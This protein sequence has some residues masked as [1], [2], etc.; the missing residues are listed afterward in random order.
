MQ[1][2]SRMLIIH[3]I[4]SFSINLMRLSCIDMKEKWNYDPKEEFDL[5]LEW[6]VNHILTKYY[7]VIVIHH[8]RH[9]VYLCMFD[10]IEQA[11]VNYFRS[12][13][14]NYDLLPLKGCEVKTLV[15]GADL[16]VTRRVT[17]RH[18]V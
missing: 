7:N 10:N 9:D 13:V 16:Y 17:Y 12:S 4:H 14:S 1:Q 15:N 6:V 5:F 11:A 8:Y 3:D 18:L 2:S